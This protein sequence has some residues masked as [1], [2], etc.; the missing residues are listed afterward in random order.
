MWLDDNDNSQ[1]AKTLRQVE[2]NLKAFKSVEQCEQYIQ[3]SI[4]NKIFILVA[5]NTLGRQ[6]VPEIHLNKLLKTV[7][8]YCFTNQDNNIKWTKRYT[9]VLKGESIT[10]DMYQRYYCRFKMFQ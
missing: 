8:I 7:Y 1:L 6:I 5:S 4:H 3:T 2:P 10:I 9:K